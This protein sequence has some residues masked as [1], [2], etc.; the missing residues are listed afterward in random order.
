[1]LNKIKLYSLILINPKWHHNCRSV[2]R[3]APEREFMDRT[4][5]THDQPACSTM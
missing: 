2:Q 1:M 5:R 4:H 3:D